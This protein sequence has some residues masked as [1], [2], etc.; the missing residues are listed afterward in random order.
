[1][2]VLRVATCPRCGADHGSLPFATVDHH[3][4]YTHFATCPATGQPLLVR[5]VDPRGHCCE[6]CGKPATELV[7]DITLIGAN[8]DQGGTNWF[9][10]VPHSAHWFCDEHDRIP[11]RYADCEVAA[12]AGLT[13]GK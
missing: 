4:R 1:M 8:P 7:T 10:F 13:E 3:E 6:A 11:I 12:A 9:C 2:K 5:E